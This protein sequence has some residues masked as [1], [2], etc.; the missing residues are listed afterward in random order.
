MK[1]L[2]TKILATFLSLIVLMS[3]MSF[4]IDK[5][6]CGETLVDIS[7]FGK[8]EDCGMKMN[9]SSEMRSMKKKKC[10][11]NVTEF[12][13]FDAF[14]QEKVQTISTHDIEFLVFHIYSYLNLYQDLKLDK[15]FYK[16]FSPPDIPKNIQVLHETFLI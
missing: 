3:S 7:Y 2:V 4:T 16:D 11:K 12:I 10:C 5:H 15:E 9:I 1:K 6:F 8:A 14:D 13:E